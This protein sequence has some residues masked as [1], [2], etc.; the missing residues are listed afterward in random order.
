VKNG[1]THKCFFWG[2]TNLHLRALDM[3]VALRSDRASIL[4]VDF[5]ST[6]AGANSALSNYSAPFVQLFP[7]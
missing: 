6:T 2:K 5:G 1:R 7:S 4:E 3:E